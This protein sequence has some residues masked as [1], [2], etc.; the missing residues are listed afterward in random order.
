MYF[1]NRTTPV[2]PLSRQL[3][4]WLGVL[5]LI[6]LPATATF[7]QSGGQGAIQ[8]T[9]TDSTGAVIPNAR[10]IAT[11]VD[12]GVKTERPTSS[13][14]LYDISPL[15]PGNYTVEVQAQGFQTHAQQNIQ[16]NAL[17]VFGLNVTLKTGSQT[18]TVTVTGAPPALDT[19]NATLGGT[20][21][22]SEY[23]ELPLL[24]S[25]N[26]QRDIT[27]FSNLLP[28]AQPGSRSSVIGGTATRLGELYVDGLPLTTIS[29]QGDNR[30][31]FNVIPLEAIDEIKVVTSGFSAEYQGA[32]L[33]N[34]NLKSGTNKYHGTV[35]DFIRNTAFD[36]WG[37][38]APW[39]TITN[40]SGVKG[41]QNSTPN[42]YGHI[43]K[44]A[45][46]QN[47]LSISFGGPVRIPHLFDG[48]DKL[49]FQ[50]TLD[51]VH[52]Q[53]APTYGF[54]TLPT[55]L[56][57]QGN[58]CELLDPAHGGCGVTGTAP[59][60]VIYDPSTQSCNGTTCTRTAFPGNVIPAAQISPLAKAM[61]QFLPA[62]I[63]T[64]LTNNYVGGIPTGY[65]NYIVSDKMDW[66]I[67]P[68]QRL[69]AA[70][71][72]GR[73]HAVPYTSGSA[74][75]PVPYLAA[76]LSTVV[77]DYLE[78]EHTFTIR[79]NLVNQ[80]KIGYQYF[81]GP[82][83]QNSTEGISKYEATTLG[84]TGLPPGQASD[85]FPGSSFAGTNAPTAWSQPDITNKT[86]THTYDLLDN[87]EWVIGRHA[88]NIGFQF[89]DL[90]ENF[91][92]F[93][94]PS[95]PTTYAWSNNETAQVTGTSYATATTGFSYA[96]YMLGAVGSTSTTLQP[97]SDI[98]DRYHP[99]SPYFQDDFKVTPKLTVNVGLRW[100]YMPGFREALDRWSFLNPN[101][102]NP[103]TGNMGSF[104]FAGNY[105]GSSASCGCDTPVHTYWK[106][107]GP[108]LGFAYSM[109]SKT[110]LRAGGAI[111]YSHGGGTGGAAANATG[112]TGFSQPVSFTA[113]AAGPTAGPVFYLNNSGY[114]AN[115]NNTNFGGPGYSLPAI[116][117]PSATSQLST[118]LVGNFVNSSGAFVKSTAGINYGD[119]YY[120]DRTPTF[121]FYNAGL[122]RSITDSITVTVN[123][124]GTISHF[125][126][127]ASGLR[128]LQSGEINPI[129]LP[130][131]ALLTKAATPTNIAAA[132]AIV[133]GCCATP[134][135]GFAAAA[136]TT[137]GSSIAT[138]GQGLKWMP[139]YSSTG[140]T[141]GLYSANAAYNAFEFSLAIRPTHGLTL[142]VNYTYNKEIDDAGTIRTGYDIPGSAILSGK[143][144]KADR[145]DRSISVLDQPQNLAVFGVYKLPFGKG[146]LGGNNFL[147]R[148]LAG[149]WVFSGTATYLSGVPLFITSSAC[150]ST[151][152]PGQGTCMP[153]VNPNFTGKSIR[154]NGKWGNGVTALT[155][156]TVSYLS[157][158]VTNTVPGEGAGGA[159]C[160]AS[161]GPFCN[162]GNYMIGD[163]PRGGA[164]NLRAPSNGRI[165]GGLRRNFN[166]TELV[167]FEFG[168]DCQ[169]ILNSVT[170]G[171]GGGG[172]ASGIGQNI[173]AST[174]G[175]LTSASSDSRDFQFSG[176]ISF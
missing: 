135:P 134:Y 84:I 11:N 1:R 5:I 32:G 60:Y 144:W 72:S 48:R 49:F 138:I 75:L 137:A 129:Y 148:A 163:A 114:N 77:G 62:P 121:Y 53:S 87:V 56:M 58:F 55:A 23:L 91:S 82:P 95:S 68:R 50:F 152:L 159:A 22:G 107:F 45:D 174:F 7:A 38:S 98:G 154:Q 4:A 120:G 165:N 65:K 100:D 166:I 73:R 131:G 122:Q 111:L 36:T 2:P 15:Q 43:S 8:G 81:G 141:W 164:F 85:E 99:M 170:F 66:D 155:L 21:Q 35:A 18:E 69:S 110:V 79:P 136:A 146:H 123:Y 151:T 125:I 173:N 3:V 47:E 116:T 59:N 92:S 83:T 142:N 52:A 162:S 33:E 61:Q 9:V 149:G 157:G 126:A 67:S 128:G 51:K 78:L 57:R 132:Q 145:I 29:Q 39:A 63:N 139:Q 167:K 97:F 64:N 172:S 153:D 108:R 93:N 86:V 70:Y 74:N 6:L 112:Q 44:P 90:M 24:V 133:A 71:T 101:I 12:T 28:G 171:G 37:F 10:V 169:N 156:G 30:P 124:A 143:S 42:S 115:L 88:L 158:A 176:R 31:V 19:T 140:D 109:D 41:P 147:V 80:F 168:V 14:G 150:T 94:S 104:Q 130:L 54:D 13:G 20:I 16:V 89:Q 76:T 102:T 161:T 113:N 175:T 26:Q 105:G 17:D 160:T 34:Y 117:P 40:A 127:G 27:Q 103:Y 96:S 106:N 25:G 118:G 46:H 119:P